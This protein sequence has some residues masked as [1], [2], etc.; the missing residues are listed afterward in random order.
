[1]RQLPSGALLLLLAALG[2]AAAAAPRP[3]LLIV[4]EISP[5][6]VILEHGRLAGFTTD[7]VRE[8]MARARVDVQIQLW[9]FKRGYLL[10]QTRPDVCIFSLT[11]LPERETLFKWV[12]PT[13]ESDWTLFG[14]ADRDYHVSK[15]EDARQYHIGTFFGDAR[16]DALSAMGYTVEPVR[17]RLSN[18]RKLLLERIDLWASSL[19][20]GGKLIAENGWEKQIVPVLT[21]R[22][23][24]LYLACNVAL[25][26]A[27]VASMNAA[28]RAMNSEGVSGAIERSY[29]GTPVT[30]RR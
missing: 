1:M 3:Q 9:P 7:K 13:H 17:D 22:R 16:G 26:D 18:P 14:R 19:Q 20:M 27:L 28:L 4:T 21:F 25:P 24:E 29:H 8:I 6:S 23:T 12:G 11:R 10:A 5:P 15:L 30:P 2:A